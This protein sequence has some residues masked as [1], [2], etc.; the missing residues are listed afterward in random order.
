MCEQAACE[1]AAWCEQV[2]AAT[3]GEDYSKLDL[4]AGYRKARAGLREGEPAEATA[5]PYSTKSDCQDAMKVA[6]AVMT[7][8]E[9]PGRGKDTIPYLLEQVIQTWEL[10]GGEGCSA[11]TLSKLAKHGA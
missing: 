9:F 10:Y 2:I 8:R 11:G 3:T 6:E 5:K 1:H 4:G 7:L